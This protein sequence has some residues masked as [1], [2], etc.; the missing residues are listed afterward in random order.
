MKKEKFIVST[1][2]LMIGGF[3]T[4]L[5]GM[6]IKMVMSRLMGSEGI[7]LYMLV[8]PTFTL[9][10]ALGQFGLPVALSKLV[11]EDKK[12]NKKLLF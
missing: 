7:G 6:I 10:I 5:L 11:A 2:I 1:L 4:K 8:L 9:F 3:L 12:N